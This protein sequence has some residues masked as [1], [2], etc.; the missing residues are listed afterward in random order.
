M[1]FS[2]FHY[3]AA[4]EEP[5]NIRCLPSIIMGLEAPNIDEL[6]AL[7]MQAPKCWPAPLL[8]VGIAKRELGLLPAPIF[9]ADN[10]FSQ[11]KLRLGDKLFHD[12]QL[13]RSGHIACASCHDRNLGWADGRQVSFGHHRLK[14][15]RNAPSIENSA[16]YSSLFWD[17]RAASLEEQALMPITDSVEMNFTLDELEERLSN[18]PQYVQLF[19]LTFGSEEVT[20]ERIAQAIA[21]FERTIL[22]RR[23][24]FDIFLMASE[25]EEESQK[26]RLSAAFS[27]ESVRGLH[28][29][30]TKA[31]CMNCHNGPEMSDS[32]FHNIG[33]TYYKR[34]YQDLGLYNQTRNYDDVGKFRT[35]GLRGVMNTKPWMHNGLFVNMEG[36]L[37]FYNM[38]G[39]ASQKTRE[40]PLAPQTSIHLKPLKLTQ[41]E[42]KDLMAFLESISGHPARGPHMRYMPEP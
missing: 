27:D 17:G 19:K 33:L 29:F 30:R 42:I 23:S 13:S 31:R 37:N 24:R 41:N 21:T 22:S 35:P 3:A 11:L 39:V 5:T 18:D 38:G 40:D 4:A 32:Q 1:I 25:I 12:P 2:C 36:L 8:D 10:P 15:K 26:Q 14:G 28:L 7:Y 16:F 34:F 20:R 6:R 9:P